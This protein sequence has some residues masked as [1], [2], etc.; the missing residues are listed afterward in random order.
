MF[1]THQY[2]RQELKLTKGHH[3]DRTFNKF[4]TFVRAK[5]TNSTDHKKDVIK[6]WKLS[7]G[8]D[9]LERRNFFLLSNSE[10]QVADLY[11]FQWNWQRAPVILRLGLAVE[12]K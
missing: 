7:A 4:T 12:Q 9:W 10:N 8:S 3:S 11:A 5:C 1:C 6:F 2:Y